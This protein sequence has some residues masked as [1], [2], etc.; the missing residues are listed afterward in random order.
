MLTV[1]NPLQNASSELFNIPVFL[2][3]KNLSATLGVPSFVTLSANIS[4]CVF[5]MD[6]SSR[7]S[8]TSYLST[9][10]PSSSSLS[11]VVTLLSSETFPPIF[12]ISGTNVLVLSV[13]SL[14]S[15]GEGLPD[16]Y[17]VFYPSLTLTNGTFSVVD[18]LRVVIS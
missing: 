15:Y 6:F 18:S 2:G 9:V 7:V 11:A 3:P 4:S 1:Y 14:S 17:N 12:S 8:T 5:G 10:F 13:G 16:I